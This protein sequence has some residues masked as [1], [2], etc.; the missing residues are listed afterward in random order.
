MGERLPIIYVRGFAGGQ[1]GI[2]VAVDD[3]FYGFNEGSTHIRVGAS[4]RPRFYQFESPL[5]RLLIDHQY[6][7]VVEGGQERKLLEAEPDSL[8]ADT[9][10]VYRF[11]DSA[12]STFG[13]EPKPYQIEKAAEGLAAYIEL[14]LA[15]TAGA[16]RVNLVAHSMGGLVCRSAMQRCMAAPETLV[17]KLVTI[18]TPHGGLDPELGGS[19]G[20]WLIDH[21]GPSGSDIFAPRRMREY[22]LPDHFPDEDLDPA[23]GRE[24]PWDPRRM[25][26]SFPV[27][28]VLSVIGTNSRDYDVAA[29]AS[30]LVMGAQSDGLVA[31]ANAYVKGSARAY[32]H[33]SHS[34]RYGL[35]NSEEAYQNLRRFLFGS[36]RVHI[37]LR[38]LE[39]RPDRVWQADVRLAIRG[40]PVLMH[41]Q[42]ADQHCPVDLN[43]EERNRP[44]PTAPLPLVTACLLPT[45]NAYARYALHLKVIGLDERGGIFGFGDHLEQ[46]ADWED[47]LIVDVAAGDDGTMSEVRWQ[48]NSTLAGRVADTEVL[49]N[50]LD[51][52]IGPASGN[53]VD[54]RELAVN[55]PEVARTLLGSA[56][57]LTL[58]VS[59]WD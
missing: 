21:F 2:D 16:S 1:R 23:T 58:T 55:L 39:L 11:Y 54:A 51:W 15:K 14:V 45:A 17:S 53:E 42:R 36:L 26:G 30:A 13:V 4:G 9:V 25:V 50:V 10:W 22:L 46:I 5:L 56:A 27:D 52:P 12:A 3:P 24:R 47:S 28:R 33:R 34:G 35:L 7:L 41:E 43:A 38:N 32:V 49:A 19:I 18:A 57:Q 37:G 59:P 6:R 48:W 29:G 40:L 20:D 31:I 44:T 8:P